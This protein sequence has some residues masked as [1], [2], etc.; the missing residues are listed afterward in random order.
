[1]V[2]S[3][4]NSPSSSLSKEKSPHPVRTDDGLKAYN[5]RTGDSRFLTPG[6]LGFLWAREV[7]THELFFFLW[8]PFPSF[9]GELLPFF[10]SVEAD[11]SFCGITGVFFFV[12]LYFYFL[13]WG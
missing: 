4:V 3:S 7:H 12:L 13:F 9:L 10:L 8:T 6:S 11:E 1:M 2:K 5:R